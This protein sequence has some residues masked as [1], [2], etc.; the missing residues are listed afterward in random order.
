MAPNLTTDA[1]VAL[2][3]KRT[4]TPLDSLVIE[5]KIETGFS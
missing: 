3:L 2:T 1:Q 4:V 5:N